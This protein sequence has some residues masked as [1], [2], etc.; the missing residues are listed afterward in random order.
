[1]T[2]KFKDAQTKNIQRERLRY[3]SEAKEKKKK[4]E[5]RQFSDFFSSPK[6]NFL[7]KKEVDKALVLKNQ[8]EDVNS[9][10][11]SPLNPQIKNL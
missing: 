11:N 8:E 2:T 1:M 4:D 7:Y 6:L 3:I 5:G 10:S 9:S